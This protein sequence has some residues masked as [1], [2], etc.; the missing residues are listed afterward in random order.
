MKV[1]KKDG[2]IQSFDADKIANSILSSTRDNKELLNESDV[3]IIIEDVI[4]KI[5][6]IRGENGNT[7]SYEITGIVISML[8]RDGFDDVISSFVGYKKD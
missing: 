5:K 7:S 8:D 1:I 2:S 6:E 4:A 3:K